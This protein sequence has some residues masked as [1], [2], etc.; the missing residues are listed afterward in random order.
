ML[1]FA[2]A[3]FQAELCGDGLRNLFLYGEEVTGAALVLVAPNLRLL[4]CVNQL[5][6]DDDGVLSLK[7]SPHQHCAHLQLARRLLRGDVSLL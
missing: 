7:H 2:H 1:P 3:Q 4:V 5:G 6:S